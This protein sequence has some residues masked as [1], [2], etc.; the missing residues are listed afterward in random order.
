M[1]FQKRYRTM[2]REQNCGKFGT[3]GCR[4]NKTL[5]HLFKSFRL[6]CDCC[7]S[8]CQLSAAGDGECPNTIETSTSLR[9]FGLT[10]A[11]RIFKRTMELRNTF[12]FNTFNASETIETV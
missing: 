2:E 8:V 5:R 4:E 9:D 7:M 10:K 12:E 11:P 1:T 6:F 3:Q